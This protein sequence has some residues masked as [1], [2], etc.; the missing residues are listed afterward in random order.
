[1]LSKSNA[2]DYHVKHFDPDLHSKVEPTLNLKK[3]DMAIKTQK[4]KQN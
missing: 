4:I 1:M 3:D 2:W